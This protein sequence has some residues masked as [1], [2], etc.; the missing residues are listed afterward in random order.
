LFRDE[1]TLLG[2]DKHYARHRRLMMLRLIWIEAIF[3]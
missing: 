3:A 2:F 1:R